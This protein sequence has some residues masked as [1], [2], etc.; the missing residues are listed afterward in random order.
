M[1]GINAYSSNLTDEQIARGR[2]RR[3]VGGGWDEIGRLQ[4]EFLVEQG[5]RPEHFLLD[6]GCGAMRGGIHFAKFL[7]PEHYFGID[8]NDRLIH[9]ALTVE[10]PAADLSDRVPAGNL[11]VT[12]RFDVPFDRT[13]DY[14]VGVSLFTHLP[15]NHIRLCL[16]KIAAVMAPGGRF[17]STFFPVDEA[18]P[19]D[20]RQPQVR[21]TTQAE[22]D[23]FHY[24]P[25]ELEWAATVAD[26]SFSCIGDWGHP[27]GQHMAEFRRR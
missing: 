8:V 11:H 4:L 1:R 23:P 6:V 14:A 25:S 22:R 19:Y 21:V 12:D 13:F 15:I 27:R 10:V 9:A 2:H 16:Y 3:H 20:V 17:F 18:A 24:R 26:W 5:M 7:E